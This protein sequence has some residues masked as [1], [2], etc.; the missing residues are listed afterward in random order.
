MPGSES[1][2]GPRKQVRAAHDQ[3]DERRISRAAR[4]HGY[5][6]PG[7]AAR[8]DL[9]ASLDDMTCRVSAVALI[10]LSDL[11]LQCRERA[12]RNGHRTAIEAACAHGSERALAIDQALGLLAQP[13]IERPLKVLHG[14]AGLAARR[15][16]RAGVAGLALSMV[17]G[18]TAQAKCAQDVPATYRNAANSHEARI[19]SI[20]SARRISR[21]H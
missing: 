11:R 2:P 8:L 13:F 12:R 20:R 19:G 15:G 17:S 16:I 6:P 5:T 7:H 4:L 18:C 10:E 1:R 9:D 14:G 3:H 21:V